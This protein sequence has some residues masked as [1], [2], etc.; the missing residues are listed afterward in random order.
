MAA[1]LIDK[2]TQLCI[3]LSE[4]P[5]NFGC[6]VH[7]AAFQARGLNFLYKAFGV[8]DIENA[9]K[10]VRALG[11]RGCGVS[12]PFK[13]AVIQ[14]LEEVEPIAQEIGAVNTVVNDGSRLTGYNTDWEGAV[15]AISDAYDVKN[16]EVVLIGAGGAA[17][18]IGF[19]L[20][21]TRVKELRIINRTDERGRELAD[22]L[23]ATFVP[24]CWLSLIGGDL[25]INATPVGM[26]PN[27]EITVVNADVMAKFQAVF[28][29]VASP[30]ITRMVEKARG[31]G[32][33]AIAGYKMSLHQA[34]KQFELYTHCDAPLDVMEESLRQY[35]LRD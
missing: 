18:A 28:D 24:W 22:R 32:L 23:G 1:M 17:R 9:L 5:S 6:T 31:L 4:K 21:R 10:G 29:V 19:G 7:N 8:Y 26:V 13:E 27:T 30:L 14:Y 16:K 12:M 25:L 34:A 33:L 35:L 20:V 15:N 11:I 3:S 2:D